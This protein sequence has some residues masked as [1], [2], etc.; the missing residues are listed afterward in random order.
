[1][2]LLV[3][4]IERWRVGKYFWNQLGLEYTVMWTVATFYFLVHRRRPHLARSSHRPRILGRTSMTN[5]SEPLTAQP[6]SPTAPKIWGYFATFGWALL[7]YLVASI[8]TICVLYL[9][10]P[11]TIPAD[12]DFSAL[13]K[14]A[15]YVSL[16]HHRHQ[17]VPGRLSDRGR[18]DGA[19]RRRK[20]TWR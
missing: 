14:D 2:F 11:A 16:I 10:D 6:P 17:R 7:A 4:N 18:A 12:L 19:R 5:G 1:M 20:T 8:V 3:T 9:W 13:M 15:R